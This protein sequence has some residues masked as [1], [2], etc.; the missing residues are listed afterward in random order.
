MAAGEAQETVR[1]LH[2]QLGMTLWESVA[3]GWC[4]DTKTVLSQWHGRAAGCDWRLS[5]SDGGLQTLHLQRAIC[6]A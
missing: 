3:C 5:A 6:E 4:G 1:T 2:V